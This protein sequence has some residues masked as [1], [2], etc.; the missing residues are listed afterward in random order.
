MIIQFIKEKVLPLIWEY[1][2]VLGGALIIAA[3]VRSLWFEPFK[4]PSTSMV[5]T[6]LVGDYLFVNKHNYGFRNPCSGERY[7][8]TETP[9]RGDVVV[10]EKKKGLACG[11]LLGSGS[12]N[13]IKRVVAIPGDE[14]AYFNKTLYVNSKPIDMLPLGEENYTT[15]RDQVLT[16]TH[17]K[18]N[19]DKIQ[20]GVYLMND[21]PAIDLQPAIVPEGQYV[22]LGDNRDNSLDSRAWVYPNWGFVKIEDIV[23]RAE[24]IFW[25]WDNGLKPRTDRIGTALIP[26][27]QSEEII[28]NP[29][30]EVQE[31]TEQPTTVK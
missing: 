7:M 9:A 6:L 25:S 19:M 11:L 18:A 23:G 4:I 8:A 14:V 5:P 24:R 13:F 22:M 27:M 12:L 15:A 16:A 29:V 30:V 31:P 26:A 1:T 2:K 28:S 21:R 10:F 17:Y 3:T 20:H